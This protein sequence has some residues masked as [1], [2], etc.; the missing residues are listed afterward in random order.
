MKSHALKNGNIHFAIF[1]AILIGIAQML[2]LQYCWN[3]VG[4]LTP[5]PRWVN[6]S[7]YAAPWPSVIFGLFD[8]LFNLIICLPAAYALCKLRPQ[9]L[10]LYVLLAVVPEF[11]WTY[12]LLFTSYPI[13]ENLRFLVPGI[14]FFLTTLPFA[15]LVVY[16]VCFKQRLTTQSRGTSV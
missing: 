13:I 4:V 7:N 14:Y 16:F 9:R 3:L 12:R 6:A 5:L 10:W 1:A 11:F 15:V 2:L 8:L